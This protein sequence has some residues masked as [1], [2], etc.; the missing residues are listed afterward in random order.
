[1][2]YSREAITKIFVESYGENAKFNPGQ[3]EAIEGVLEGRRTLV[4]QKTGW[5][6]SLVY[7]MATK[8]IRRETGK[9]TIIISP[10][11]ALMDNQVDSAKRLGLRV[12]TINSNNQDDW[13][14]ILAD[15]AAGDVDALIVAPERLA[16]KDFLNSFM[17]SLA[18][19]VGLFVVD[20]AHC[21]SDWGHDF[22]PDYRRLVKFIQL[23]P[24]NVPVLAT[25]A[26]ANDRVVEDIRSQLGGD[27][28][29]SRGELMRESIAIQTIPLDSREERLAWLAKNINGVPGTGIVYCLTTNDC[30]L[31]CKWLVRHGVTADVFYSKSG[32]SEEKAAVIERFNK[33]EIKALVATTAFGMGYDKD[34][35]GFVIHFQ[36]PKNV[37]EYYQEIGRAG[38]HIPAAYAIL[39]Y[40]E[41]DD[42][43]NN[44][45]INSAFPTEAEMLDVVR[46]VADNP[47]KN[48]SEIE[49]YVNMKPSRVEKTLKYLEVDGVVYKEHTGYY[50]SAAAW[51]PDMTHSKEITAIRRAELNRMTDFCYTDE[52]YMQFIAREL[53]DRKACTCGKCSN[54]LVGKIF[55]T[56]ITQA[57]INEAGKFIKE[58]FNIIEPRKK[59][60]NKTCS[61]NGKSRIEQ[62]YQVEPG[63]V[64]S[65]YGDAG[66]GTMVSEDK[67]KRGFFREE[68]VNAAAERLKEFVRENDIHSVTF[69]PSRRRPLLVRD[70]AEKLAAVLG[71]DFFD[72][73]EKCADTE[74]QKKFNNSYM[75]WQNADKSFAI[76]QVRP[77]NILL[78]DDMVDSKW[79]F[80][81]C[82]YKMRKSGS[83]K[84]YPF[85]LAN[86]AG[87]GN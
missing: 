20:E 64:L 84:I 82:G 87:H 54:C 9:F 55:D 11:L 2:G 51:T 15:I 24:T 19:R 17:N 58:D 72:A 22:R 79:T 63:L 48:K 44:Y 59:W 50:R 7:F 70:F 76:K 61:E 3:L 33:N 86:S 77:D 78:V 30:D 66:W 31:V 28:L 39:M 69:I 80:T 56:D 73:I 47:G 65:N 60:P 81:C 83:G 46:A 4:V 41:Q 52:C 10:L 21:I 12:E 14:N 5:G 8:M 36:R 71:I 26:T 16:N 38:R 57:E 53:D 23:L 25:T 34:D 29:I 62:E 37:V 1:M 13:E 43:I 75:Q 6:K 74:C 32:T 18:S 68:L 67:Y 35:I 40:G 42:I 27:I 49:S 45:F 85:A